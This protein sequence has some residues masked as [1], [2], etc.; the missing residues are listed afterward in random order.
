MT[1]TTAAAIPTG[2]A[3][4]IARL[5]DSRPTPIAIG[6]SSA[7]ESA[8][9]ENQALTAPWCVAERGEHLARRLVEHVGVVEDRAERGEADVGQDG[10]EDQQGLR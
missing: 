2:T 9:T 7:A 6:A 10:G 1:C 5:D 4:R 3:I 8:R